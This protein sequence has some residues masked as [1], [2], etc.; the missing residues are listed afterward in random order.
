ML[1]G[2]RVLMGAEAAAFVGATDRLRRVL[3]AAGFD[4][5]ILPAVWERSTFEQKAAGSPVLDQMWVFKDKGDRDCCLIPEVTG[6]VQELYRGQWE[7][8]LPKPIR[9]F[10]VA[11]CYRYE[12]PQA[13]RY[14]EFT[15][16][17]VEIL[18][19]DTSKD[20]AVAALRKSLDEFGLDYRFVPA[21]KRGLTYYV[22]DG[23]E[24]ECD[25]LG[26]QKQVAGGG[27]YPEG[28]GWAIGLDRLLLA[29]ERQGGRA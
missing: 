16:V 26:S 23:F 9:L 1:R 28:I 5:I 21:V 6:V 13:G 8:S 19:P 3:T 25:S 17:G 2:T 4:E 18:G 14:R 20:E 12:R 22:E 29:L 7:Q 11:R 15:Q 24:V 27:R 10:Y